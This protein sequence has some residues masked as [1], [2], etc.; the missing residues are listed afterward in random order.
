MFKINTVLPKV[1]LGVSPS[2]AIVQNIF[3]T[4]NTF[5]ARLRFLQENHLNYSQVTLH[6]WPIVI[7]SGLI[8]HSFIRFG[9]YL[10]ISRNQIHPQRR[11]SYSRSRFPKTLRQFLGRF[12]CDTCWDPE[13]TESGENLGQAETFSLVWPRVLT[14]PQSGWFWWRLTIPWVVR[15]A[16]VQPEGSRLRGLAFGRSF[17]PNLCHKGWEQWPW[18]KSQLWILLAMWIWAINLHCFLCFWIKPVTK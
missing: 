4:R 1:I 2:V 5:R 17:P 10:A 6:L 12:L 18:F 9:T 7:S 13:L 11:N 8:I 15:T 3:G 16:M 14:R